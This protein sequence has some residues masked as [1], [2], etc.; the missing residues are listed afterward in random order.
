[1]K[2]PVTQIYDMTDGGAQQVVLGL[3]GDCDGIAARAAF[4]GPDQ[5]VVVECEDSTRTQSVFTLVTAVDPGATLIHAT[6]G[7]APRL[8]DRPRELEPD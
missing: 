7:R 8:D 4:S 2:L 1:M 3:L 6:T 5:Y